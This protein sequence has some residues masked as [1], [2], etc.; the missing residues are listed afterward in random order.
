MLL[1]AHDS[2][3]RT[4]AS[5]VSAVK[6]DA[7]PIENKLCSGESQKSSSCRNCLRSPSLGL[8]SIASAI[9][10][11]TPNSV[12]EGHPSALGAKVS[13]IACSERCWRAVNFIGSDRVTN[14]GESR[15][16]DESKRIKVKKRRAA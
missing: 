16:E 15:K 4:R 12:A 1:C 13:Q 2:K 5:S 9:A 8:K 11:G 7:R 10:S 14:G 6:R 3:T